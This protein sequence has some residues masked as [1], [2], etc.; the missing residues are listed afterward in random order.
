M[1]LRFVRSHFGW[2]QRIRQH[3]G[4]LKGGAWKTSKK[5][6]WEMC[7]VIHGFPS[8]IIALQFEWAWQ[9]PLKSLP[10]R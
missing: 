9:N 3:N 10:I 2:L 6:P 5:R 1:C 7:L 4:E 8:K